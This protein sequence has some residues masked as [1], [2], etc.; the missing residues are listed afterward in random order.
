MKKRGRPRIEIDKNTFEKLC[1]LFCTEEDIAYF[2]GCS[3]DTIN[4]W[5]KKTYGTNFADT[6]KKFKTRGKISLR[7]LQFQSAEKGNVT[8]QIWLGKQELNQKECPEDW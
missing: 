2:F 3:I 1:G 6:Y 5:C 7:R 4:R 8:M